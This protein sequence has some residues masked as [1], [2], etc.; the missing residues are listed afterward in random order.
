MDHLGAVVLRRTGKPGE[1]WVAS[2]LDEHNHPLVEPELLN[3]ANEDCSVEAA[4]VT[5]TVRV[6]LNHARLLQLS[7]M[8]VGRH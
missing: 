8:A 2:V 1:P 6:R 3:T 7:R 5:S 4:L